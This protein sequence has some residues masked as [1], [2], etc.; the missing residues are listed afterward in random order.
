MRVRCVISVGTEEHVGG[1]PLHAARL[2]DSDATYDAIQRGY[3]GVAGLASRACPIAA[4]PCEVGSDGNA[5]A[6]SLPQA[7]GIY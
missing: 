2:T 1:V 5:T 7:R 4:A 6:R 3:A